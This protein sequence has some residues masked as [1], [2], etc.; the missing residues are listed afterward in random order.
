MFI[1]IQYRETGTTTLGPDLPESYVFKCEV[2]DRGKTVGNVDHP[3][4]LSTLMYNVLYSDGLQFCWFPYTA[5]GANG[6]D[7]E[8]IIMIQLTRQQDKTDTPGP[9]KKIKM[10]QL[11]W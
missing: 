2:V 1:L 4:R 5:T 11:H 7:E 8:K 3:G 6:T 10:I 9:I